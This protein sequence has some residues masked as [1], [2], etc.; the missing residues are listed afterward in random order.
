MRTQ[1]L[2]NAVASVLFVLA[3]VSTVQA[4]SDADANPVLASGKGVE[5]TRTDL[6]HEL[7]LIPAERRQEILDDPGAAQDLVNQMYFRGRMAVLAEELGYTEEPLVQARMQRLQERLFRELVPRRHVEKMEL[8]DFTEAAR[9]YYENHL[10]EF[11]PEEEVNA[12]HILLRAPDAEDKERRRAEAE[13]LLRQIEEGASFSEMAQEHG[14][15]GT[16][17]LGGDLG[18]F[19]REK[20]VEEFSDAVFAMEPGEVELVETRFGF[21]LV[22]FRERRG[23]EPEPF[24][25]VEEDIK[26]RLRQE[27]IEE[28]LTSYLTSVASP[29]DA[30]MDEEA[31]RS[32]LENARGELDREA[33]DSAAPAGD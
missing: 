4:A 25:A 16:R 20:M 21:H 7:R 18:F 11:V 2:A 3:A 31:I 22:E 15:D 13:E 23:G 6:E 9:T 1:L 17:R 5:I 19:S 29:A 12:A 10:D 26:E 27:Y 24:E 33:T 32:T 14:E 28:E 8:P 30:E